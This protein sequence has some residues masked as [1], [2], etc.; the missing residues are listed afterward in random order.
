MSLKVKSALALY[1]K[2]NVIR[3][4]IEVQNFIVALKSAHKAP[5]CSYATVV[6]VKQLHFQLNSLTHL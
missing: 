1:Q 2:F 5:F 4:T 6:G 3:S